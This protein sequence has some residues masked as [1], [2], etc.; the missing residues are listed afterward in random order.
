MLL[1]CLP[2]SNLYRDGTMAKAADSRILGFVRTV[3]WS[4]KLFDSGLRVI[5]RSNCQQP[6]ASFINDCSSRTW[7]GS[8]A[9][10]G[11]LTDLLL[12]RDKACSASLL[13]FIHQNA[14][15]FPPGIF[16]RHHWTHGLLRFR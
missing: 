15:S 7:L 13:V 3:T 9:I 8:P 10:S 14:K 5:S 1:C 11:G 2:F 12:H 6:L 16:C 4:G